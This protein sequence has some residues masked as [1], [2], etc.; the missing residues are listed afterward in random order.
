MRRAS[1]RFSTGQVEPEAAVGGALALLQN[2]DEIMIDATHGT[3]VLLVAEAS[4]AQH[5]LD[6][7]RHRPTAPGGD[8]DMSPACRPGGLTHPAAAAETG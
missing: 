3:L 2:R 5:R 7:A 6:A 4:S 1:H 8:Q